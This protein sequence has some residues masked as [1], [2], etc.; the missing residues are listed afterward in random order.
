MLH[1]ADCNE[2]PFQRRMLKMT[3]PTRTYCP[4]STSTR[5]LH[6]NGKERRRLEL[7]QKHATIG[8]FHCLYYWP[9]LGHGLYHSTSYIF[10]MR[11]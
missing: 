11:C 2:Y 4:T 6:K 8:E 10:A 5:S 1:C 3:P 7:V 9:T